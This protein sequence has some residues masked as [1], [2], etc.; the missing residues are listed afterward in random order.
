MNAYPET[1]MLIGG[2]WRSDDVRP[3]YNPFDEAEIG[4]RPHANTTDLADAVSAAEDGL[5]AWGNLGPE[6]REAIMVAAARLLRER[7]ADIARTISLEGGKPVAEATAETL[8]AA[9]IIEWDGHE[10]RRLYGR[11]IPGP[12]GIHN[13]VYRQPIGVVAAFTPWNFPISSPSRKVGGALGAGCSIVLKAAEDTPGGA[14][15]LVRAF[16]DAGLP[17]GVINLIYGDPPSI[18]EYLIP[19]PEVRLVTFTGSVPV[20]KHLAALAGQH[21]KPVIMELGGHAP[22]FVSSTA[23][24]QLA[25]EMSI[26]GKSMNAGQVCVSPTRFFVEDSVYDDFAELLTKRAQDVRVGS[27]QDAATTMGPLINARRVE[28]VEKLVDDAVDTGARL[29]TGGHRLGGRGFGYPL[30]IM[31]EVPDHARAMQEEPFGPLAL[32]TRVSGVDE[33]ITRA[34]SVPYGLAGYGFTESARDIAALTERLE[35]GVLAINHLVISVP[36]APYGGIKDSGYGREGGTEGL[37]C[38]T[39]SKNVLTRLG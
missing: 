26:I 28:A 13:A 20:G 30:T 1:R 27:G 24:L 35:V 7:S 22:V 3:V 38:Y 6:G 32:L 9:D 15:E 21:M 17:A 11:I 19:Q 37:G 5:R 18:S 29:L 31:G 4:A 12:I 34:N 39:V 2:E 33:A 23:D 10:G 36:E 14:F 16:V 8:R 25:V